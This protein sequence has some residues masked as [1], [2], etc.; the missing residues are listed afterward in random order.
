MAR[1]RNE[2]VHAKAKL[3]MEEGYP[4][5]QAHAIASSML[6]AG[7]L[8]KDLTYYSVEEYPTVP[9]RT[10]SKAKAR[11]QSK[12]KSGRAKVTKGTKD[13]RTIWKVGSKYFFSKAKAEAYARD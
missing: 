4:S 3:L 1:T 10:K 7:R 12:P 8:G 11:V 5:R 2:L 9:K 13:G 6:R